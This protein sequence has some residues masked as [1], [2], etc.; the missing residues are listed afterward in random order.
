MN[1][2]IYSVLRSTVWGS[3]R[4]VEHYM[5]STCTHT[6][7]EGT[8]DK[9]KNAEKVRDRDGTRERERVTQ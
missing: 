8:R 2:D 7:R 1:M 9:A 5:L 3:A 6:V 4:V